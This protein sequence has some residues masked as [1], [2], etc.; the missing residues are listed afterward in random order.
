MITLTATTNGVEFTFTDSKY[1]LY[2]N[3]TINAPLNSLSLVLD[4]S[5]AATFKKAA[6]NDVFVSAP[7]SEFGMTKAELEEFYENNM[8]GG[9][10]VDPADVLDIVESATSY[11]DGVE[12]DSVNSRINFKHGNTIEGYIDAAPF[13]VDGMVSDVAI[14]GGNLVI[15]FNTDSGKQP[16]SIPLT[17][18]FDPSNYYDKNAIDTII[19]GVNDSIIEDEEVI[20]S[21]LNDLNERKLDASAY[22]PTDLTN[23]YNKTEVNG[24]LADK[25]D[26][27]SAG[28]NI[29]IV[30]DTISCTLP[31]SVS[32]GY[33]S[34]KSVSAN[35]KGDR[36][37][38]WGLGANVGNLG[39]SYT[40]NDAFAFGNYVNA[41][42]QY[43]ASFGTYNASVQNTGA[44]GASG[45]TLFCVGNGTAN[46]ARHNAFEIRLNGDIYITKD[47]ADVKL[48][49]QLGGGSASSAIT[50]GDTNAV[51]GG[52]VYDK[53][54]EVEQV[55]AAALNTLNTNMGGLKFVK[56]SQQEYDNLAVKDS[57]TM[58]III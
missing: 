39:S 58:Y 42:N 48:Q 17:D 3:G 38:A 53:F 23:Y 18:I 12:Y 50:S 9:G 57:S 4:N 16:I 29:S 54:D 31:I 30:N 5:G 6:S 10:G 33:K 34:I 27:L 11:Y 2:G 41:Y 7:L 43:E 36:N 49:D 19:S 40:P 22:T 14:S 28:T 37:I 13:I 46:N 47:G 35:V 52:A 44:D 45:T 8:V 20:S 21:A 51:Q 32:T 26:E 24:L 55:T 1:Y 15:E 25:Q 56:L